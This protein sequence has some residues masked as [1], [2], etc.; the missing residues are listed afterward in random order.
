[1]ETVQQ[2][3]NFFLLCEQ[4]YVFSK[5]HF[6]AIYEGQSLK[7]LL[8]QRWTGHLQCAMAVKSSRHEIL[9]ALEIVSESGAVTTEVSV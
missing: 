5:R 4:L 6:V 7:T 3:R 2:V 1:M 8:I 9:D